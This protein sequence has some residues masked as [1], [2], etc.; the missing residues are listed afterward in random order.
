M[1]VK[2]CKSSHRAQKKRDS[3]QRHLQRQAEMSNRQPPANPI[4]WESDDDL[5]PETKHHNDNQHISEHTPSSSSSTSAS[6]ELYLMCL[7]CSSVTMVQ[8]DSTSNLET[9]M[10][11]A[12]PGRV[13]LTMTICRTCLVKNCDY[14]V[15]GETKSDLLHMMR[16]L[17]IS[18]HYITSTRL[19]K[20]LSSG[21]L[22]DPHVV[23]EHGAVKY[24]PLEKI[25]LAMDDTC[26]L[27]SMVDCEDGYVQCYLKGGFF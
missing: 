17:S 7:R 4:V 6:K 12:L 15:T 8:Y 27:K 3:L 11:C 14:P 20:L 13:Q 1:N 10:D 21:I 24:I 25:I 9:K 23:T 2:P 26:T 19:Y 16:I 22:M 18:P 5:I